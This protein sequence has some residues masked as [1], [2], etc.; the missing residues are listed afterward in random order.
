[1]SYEAWG[2][3]TQAKPLEAITSTY[4]GLGILGF[5]YFAIGITILIGVYNTTKSYEATGFIGILLV[6]FGL[7]NLMSTA[8]I[9][10]AVIF[11]LLVFFGLGLA[12]YKFRGKNN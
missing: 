11:A 1:M 6:G 5:F 10:I 2:Y 12:L 7:Y 9:N 8:E 3:L 4:S